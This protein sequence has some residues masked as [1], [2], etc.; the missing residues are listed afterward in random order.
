LLKGTDIHV[1]GEAAID[2]QAVEQATKSLRRDLC[3]S[4]FECQTPMG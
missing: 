3:C 1:V 2:N 4:T